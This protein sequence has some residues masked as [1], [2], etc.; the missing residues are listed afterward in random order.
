MIRY[1]RNQAGFTIVS[2]IFILVILSLLGLAMVTVNAVM[3][4]TSAQSAQGVHAYYAAKSGLEWAV[5]NA[6]GR[7]QDDHDNIC[8]NPDAAPA[9]ATPRTTA[10]TVNGFNVEVTCNA[11]VGNFDDG[12]NT[13]NLDN[14]TVIAENGAPA[15]HPDQIRRTIQAT[16]TRGET[17]TAG[18][19]L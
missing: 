4:T 9:I 8:G 3:Q 19:C 18:T 6:T 11:N 17:L 14:I 15:G 16:V 5:Y 2:A 12:G 1:Y 10:L 7:C 13:F